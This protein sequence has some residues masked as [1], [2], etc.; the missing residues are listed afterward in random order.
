MSR[1]LPKEYAHRVEIRHERL[2]LALLQSAG[3][4]GQRMIA[5]FNRFI[6]IHGFLLGR[7]VVVDRKG[8]HGDKK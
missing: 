6:S 3:K 7:S 1:Q 8:V 4:F 2:A 5:S